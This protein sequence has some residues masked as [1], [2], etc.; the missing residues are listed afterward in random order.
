MD[1]SSGF[2]DPRAVA[3]LSLD[4][5]IMRVGIVGSRGYPSTYSGYE[6]LVR[7]LAPFLS[8]RGHDVVVY[9]RHHGRGYRRREI[10]G[11]TTLSVPAVE[12]KA[13]ST[14]SAVASAARHAKSE[15]LSCVLG[16]NLA[17]APGLA[18]L[19]RHGTP[20]ALNTDGLEWRRGKWGPVA[21]AVFFT[22]AAFAAARLDHLIS[23]SKAIQDYYSL[24]F[25]SASSYIPYGADSKA[26]S[27]AG[28]VLARALEPGSYLLVVA[29]LIPENSIELILD[30]YERSGVDF[31]LVVV[32]EANY[33]SALSARLRK[34]S[35]RDSIRWLG[36]V[37]DQELLEQLWANAALYLHGHSVG[38]TNP[39]LLQA[40]GLGA[41]TLAL[42]TPFNREVLDD[43]EDSLFV[44]EAADL[45]ARIR[46]VC[47]GRDSVVSGDAARRIVQS[48]YSWPAVLS[49]Y[50][51]LLT[52]IARTDQPAVRVTRS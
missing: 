16:V 1:Q 31:P 22:C 39:S 28:R 43:N 24:T 26:G 42:D 23:D 14:P 11:I 30:S 41:P 32:G 21:K 48:R 29:R 49:S 10:D 34:E 5:D 45:S 35:E 27:G 50:E 25:G 46:D 18:W 40:L 15:G 2:M 37:D 44:A 47:A 4:A 38:G 12:T 9:G 36:H 3:T 52:D 8:G 7:H 19:Q 20:V 13:L 6:T 17:S 33:R 51:A